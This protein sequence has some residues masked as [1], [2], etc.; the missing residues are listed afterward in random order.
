[1]DEIQEFKNE[2]G[3]ELIAGKLGIAPLTR[4]EWSK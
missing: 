2:K 3:F 1:M 4:K